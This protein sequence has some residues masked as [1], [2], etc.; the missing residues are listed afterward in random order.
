MVS[1]PA[2]ST[3]SD[4]FLH[5]CNSSALAH[6]DWVLLW[7]TF[8][9]APETGKGR[10]VQFLR[11]HRVWRYYAGFFPITL[12]KTVDLDP[13]ETYVFG[14]HPHGFISMGAWGNFATEGT[15]FEELFPGIRNSLLTLAT[16]FRIPVSGIACLVL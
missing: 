11:R 15:G 16:N 14:Y 5:V 13:G 6:C 10:R 9:D 4:I 12:H 7:L 2:G 3:Y 8:D 1:G